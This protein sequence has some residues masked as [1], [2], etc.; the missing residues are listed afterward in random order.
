M[1][2]QNPSM[3]KNIITYGLLL[4]VVSVAFNIMLYTMDMHYQQSFMAGI[5]GM[6]ILVGVLLYA[7]VNYKKQNEGYLSLSEALK[8][9]LG[10]T[11]VSAIIG[12]LYSFV[13]TEFLDPD[14]VQKAMDFQIEQMRAAN[15]EISQEQIDM[16]RGMSEKFSSPLFRSAFQIIGALFVGFIVSLIGGLIV[17]KSRPE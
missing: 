3:K 8:L 1:S 12:V 2:S 16:R 4:G 15:P 6:V 9:G 13:L 7:F 11:L 10:I 17:K 14:M 5:V